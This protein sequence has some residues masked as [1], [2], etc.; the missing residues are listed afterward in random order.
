MKICEYGCGQE[1]KHQFKNGK[2]CCSEVYTKCPFI[3]D[4]YRK[5]LLVGNPSKVKQTREKMSYI[6]KHSSYKINVDNNIL[7]EYGCGQPARYIVNKINQ[8]LCCS[9]YYNSCPV[10]I[11][12]NRITSGQANK[13]K[14]K[15]Y[16][17]SKLMKK[18]NPMFINEHK[19]KVIEITTTDEYRKRM[20]EKLEILW[21]D[22]VFI[23]N[24]K[25]G[26]IE[27]G[28]QIPDE[29][30]TEYRKYYSK[31]YHYTRKT[32]KKYNHIINPENKP[33]GIKTGF[34]NIDHIYSIFDGFKN[35]I[36]A[37]IIGSYVNLQTIPWLKNLKKQRNSWITKEELL[38]NYERINE[39]I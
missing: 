6:K 35:N 32:L 16:T 3:K 36:D 30:L 4:K 22:D 23:K 2:W 19:E 12:T 18:Q 26:R 25:N 8:K 39:N 17:H 9:K 38:E 10:M 20:S 33:I 5:K 1:A 34:Y 28:T 14:N 11:E 37:K 13:N 21:K 31:V 29:C 27:A 24:V 7:C 15:R